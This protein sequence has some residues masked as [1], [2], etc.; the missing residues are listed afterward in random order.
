MINF[1]VHKHYKRWHKFFFPTSEEY[2]HALLVGA[3]KP[4]K[5]PLYNEL[6]RTLRSPKPIYW[7]GNFR[8]IVLKARWVIC[9]PNMEKLSSTVTIRRKAWVQ[10]SVILSMTF[11]KWLL[12]TKPVEPRV[13]E[14]LLE[15]TRDI[16]RKETGRQVMVN[17][18][19]LD[20][21]HPLPLEKIFQLV[22]FSDLYKIYGRGHFR[23]MM[24]RNQF[25]SR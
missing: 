2:M 11:S 6:K 5:Y 9:R 22:L 8:S 13:G 3:A 14:I 19:K 18:R 21:C 7:L 1:E 25:G 24:S 4:R 16:L 15:P 12:P 10:N 20:V 23:I 17:Q